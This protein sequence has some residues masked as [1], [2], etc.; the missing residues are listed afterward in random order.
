MLF[1]V[2]GCGDE[3]KPQQVV[4]EE[5]APP[6]PPPQPTSQDLFAQLNIDPRIKIAED[7]VPVADSDPESATR[8][9]KA[10]LTFFDAMVRGSDER[11]NPMLA[12]ADQKVLAELVQAGLFAPAA[13]RVTQ[14]VLGCGQFQH[15]LKLVDAVF[16]LIQSGPQ[17]EVQLWM[18]TVDENGQATFDAVPTPPDILS[19]LTGTK[20]APRIRQWATVLQDLI[21]ESRKPD[22][23]IDFGQVDYG[24]DDEGNSTSGGGGAPSTPSSAP[25]PGKRDGPGRRVPTGKP[26]TPPKPP[27]MR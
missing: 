20:A 1:F 10:V 3:E 2:T 25:S 16:A 22:E 23:A 4:Q 27:G 7:E 9:L 17:F 15:E 13:Q 14:V 8:K 11:L 12:S 18:Y 21:E 19:K 24:V 26:I 5:V 6:P